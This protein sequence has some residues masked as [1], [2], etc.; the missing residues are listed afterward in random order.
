MD[1]IQ[2]QT[3][4]GE[5]LEHQKIVKNVSMHQENNRK[6]KKKSSILGIFNILQ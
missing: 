2:N 3:K 1:L 6:A 5:E 4:K